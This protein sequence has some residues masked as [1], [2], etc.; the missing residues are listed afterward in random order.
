MT[1]FTINVYLATDNPFTASP[2]LIDISA[3]V[4]M[5]AG[6]T[7]TRGRQDEFSDTNPATC[8]LT[9]DNT[10][11]RFTDT[12]TSGPYYPNLHRNNWIIVKQTISAVQ[13]TRYVG[14]VQGWP[15]Q[16]VGKSAQ[17]QISAVCTMKLIA[18]ARTLRA[19][20]VEETAL[21]NLQAIWP[22]TE[23]PIT[24]A[25]QGSIVFTQAAF[26]DVSGQGFAP[27]AIAPTG[28]V[29]SSMM[30][31]SSSA[32]TV[33][34]DNQGLMTFTGMSSSNYVAVTRN[35]SGTFGNGTGNFSV[36]F[37]MCSGTVSQK[38][39]QLDDGTKS[40]IVSITA[41]G[42]LSIGSAVDA[43]GVVTAAFTA[44][45]STISSAGSPNIPHHIVI[46][47]TNAGA[48]M[49]VWQDGTQ[50]A[51]NNT[52]VTWSKLYGTITVGAPTYG[53]TAFPY[54]GSIGMISMGLPDVNW[55]TN[56]SASV[57][58]SMGVNGKAGEFTDDRSKR[59]CSYISTL[60][61]GSWFSH[62]S[63]S[64]QVGPQPSSGSSALSCIQDM[65]HTEN[66]ILRSSRDGH[67]FFGGRSE[68]TGIGSSFTVSYED[69][70]KATVSPDS[71]SYT[72][73]S[74]IGSRYAGATQTLE[75]SSS[76][77][78]YGLYQQSYNLY[79]QTDAQTTL[80]LNFRLARDADPP[81]RLT[82]V[83]KGI[84][85]LSNFATVA[86]IEI[87]QRFTISSI[88]TPMLSGLGTSYWVEGYQEVITYNNHDLTIYTSPYNAS[89]VYN[90]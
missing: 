68:R 62:S 15:I 49:D 24:A 37:W 69:L 52:T 86:A 50:I 70:D 80:N 72:I 25:S 44:T 1:A 10:D 51:T 23:N 82:P 3:Y 90:Y 40:M 66:G 41:G 39:L 8:T 58:Y 33:G 7:I 54:T 29:T 6:I 14:Y 20:L 60:L 16:V 21:N 42:F 5:N 17:V 38:L 47:V 88:P 74:V 55:D 83:I 64:S 75:N 9:L 13:T 31:C 27:L 63:T 32:L 28:T 78:K 84:N 43:T 22:C 53:G 30:T 18:Q 56:T 48:R 65:S 73:N 61:S 11:G 36:E 67:L 59:I 81:R 35:I 12:N 87:S 19:M 71:D 89:L 85:T 4:D 46:E 34:P 76:I 2:T 77:A 79:N 26:G 45:G 57:R